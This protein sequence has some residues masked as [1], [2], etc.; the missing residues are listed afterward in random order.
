MIS[1]RKGI[2][3]DPS[4]YHVIKDDRFWEKWRREFTSTARVENVDRILDPKFVPQPGADTELFNEQQK[5]LY[6]VL[7]RALQSDK[8]KAIVRKHQERADAQRICAEIFDFWATSTTA[9]LSASDIMKYITSARI[10][11]G[12]WRG[13]S[14]AFINN[15]REQV[16]IYE[17]TSPAHDK[18]PDLTKLS[19]LQNAVAGHD[20]LRRVKEMADTNE[21]INGKHMDYDQ[22][23]R[24]LESAAQNYDKSQK[25]AGKRARRTVYESQR[26]DGEPDTPPIYGEVSSEP[27]KL[28]L[29]ANVHDSTETFDEPGTQYDI[30]LP[31]DVLLANQAQQTRDRNPSRMTGAQWHSLSVDTQKLWDQISDKDKALILGNTKPVQRPP[32]T[33]TAIPRRINIH[34]LSVD[35]YLQLQ[36]YFSSQEQSSK[37]DDEKIGDKFADAVQEPEDLGAQHPILAHLS[38]QDCHKVLPSDIRNILSSRSGR[39]KTKPASAARQVN[40]AKVMYHVSRHESSSMGALVDRG[41]NGGIAGSD[42]RIINYTDKRVDVRGIDNHELVDIPIVTAGGVVESQNGPVIAILHQYAYHG[43]GKT[44]HSPA[45]LEAYNQDVNDRSIK[46]DGGLQRIKTLDGYVHPLSIKNGLAYSAIRPYTDAEWDDLP[47]VVWTGDKEWDPSVMDN[48]YHED[49]EHWYDTI[50]DLAENPHHQLFDEFGNYK[51]REAA[52]LDCVDV[53][54][55]L[56]QDIGDCVDA[57]IDLQDTLQANQHV[58]HGREPDYASLRRFFAFSPVETIKKTFAVT[59]QM[60]RKQASTYLR[61]HYK[62][63]NPALNV[64]RRNEGVA[65]DTIYSDEPAIDDGARAA[66]LFVGCDSMVTDVYALHTEKQFV[67]TLEDNIRI[68]G[69][70][71]RLVSDR[72]QVEISNRV[73]DILR[74]LFIRS[75][76]SEPHRQ[77]QNPAERRIQ[78]V[79]RMTNNVLNFTGAP[80][81]TWLLCMMY[82]CFVLNH[83]ATESLQWRTPIESLTGT[84]PDISPLLRFS[85]WEPVYYKLD[86]NSFP[87]ESPEKLG[88]WVGVAEHVGHMMTYKILT[89]D[90]YKIIYRSDVRSALDPSTRNKRIDFL[91][92]EDVPQVVKSLT[93]SKSDQDD[94]SLPY[95]EST[96]ESPSEGTSVPTFDPSDLIG[97]TFLLPEQKDGQRHRASIVELLTDQEN[98]LAKDPSRIKFL[99]SVNNDQYE[100]ILTY[101]DVVSYCEKDDLEAADGII[102]KFRRITGHEGPLTNKDPNWK[103]SSYNVMVEWETGEIT[104]EPLALI[105]TDDPVTCALY[106]QEKGLLNEPGWKHFSR[107]AKRQKKLLRMVN[108]A[109]LRSYR[110][111]PKYKFGYE[112]PQTHERA[113]ELDRLAGNTKWKDAETKEMLCLSDYH[114]FKDLGKGGKA[115][116]GYKKIQVQVIYDVKHDGRHRARVVAGGHLTDEP[117]ESVYSG[118]VSLR[119]IRLLVFLAELNDQEVWATD[120]SSAYLEAKTKEKVYIIAGPAFGELEGHTL[121][122]YKAL[123]GLRTSGV[124]W[125]ERLADCL[126]DMGFFPCMAEP[127]IWMRPKDGIYEYI[128]VYVDDLAI[129][130]KDPQAIIDV[131]VVKHKF[132]MKGTGPIGYHLGCNFARDDEGT[133]CMQ[134]RTYI[135]KMI[136]NYERLYGSKPKE[137]YLSPLEKGDHPEIDLSPLLDQEGI[138]Q[139]Q[140]LVGAMQWAVSIGRID[141]TTAVMTM[142][143]F[144]VAPREGHL[145]RCKRIYGYLSKMRHGCIRFRTDEPDYSAIPDIEYDWAHSV[146]GEVKEVIPT[147]CPPPLGKFVTT[148]HFKDAN[149]YHDLLTGRAITGILHLVNKTPIDWYSKKQSTVETATYGSEFSAARTRI[150]Q[151]V[152]LRNTLRYLGVPVREKSYMFGDNK[153]VVDSATLPHAKLHKRH[154]ML[155]FHRVREAIA[156][157]MVIFTFV[158][159][160]ANPADILSKHW[161]YQQIWPLLQ[162]LMFWKGDTRKLL[163]VKK[164]SK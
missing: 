153:T 49:D 22:Y 7:L 59:T 20:D 41:A 93:P 10:D 148:T 68:R 123:Y 21:L 106:A 72:A 124:R 140:S 136:M 56:P 51:K 77:H 23:C 76:Q 55:G 82:I 35:N 110:R 135:E 97:R 163:E 118:V 38:E 89:D 83:I 71:D 88:R 127:D 26:Q 117:L 146:Y 122:I 61:K 58:V 43:Q 142:S 80:A 147:N 158:E 3:R 129:C 64:H 81:F 121:V 109:K 87:S 126:R 98:K 161:G 65:T 134:P 138:Q 99:C 45:Q 91:S 29:S 78:T 4:R 15:W 132:K 75:W 32:P 149:L 16:R 100:E 36:A 57:C 154:T 9:S 6:D 60:A 112:V 104:E 84:T 12:K 96:G 69:A 19:L 115:P 162:P 131:L 103:G 151:I 128:G 114:V 111:A 86:D 73:K 102:W 70:M 157:K 116:E 94:N 85:F 159:G 139:Y 90:T 79:K 130:S 44:I 66:Q 40:M 119:G 141:I 47:H 52:F 143:S 14:E 39:P 125:H 101:N 11:D 5:Y 50:S 120:I 107:L 48:A 62:S 155:S 54:C 133:L 1:F 105:A 25:D 2:K 42:V 74:A 156:S 108:Q 24:L 145:D 150:E 67:N 152:D 92:G 37:L 31:I 28:N 27:G 164:P 53:E 46:V 17:E 63:P 95:G 160:A 33:R 137:L 13:T 8:G 113:M 34:D 30:D 18:L 144:R